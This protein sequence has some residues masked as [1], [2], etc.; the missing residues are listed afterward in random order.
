VTTTAI[1]TG[2]HPDDGE[3]LST[4][5]AAVMLGVTPRTLYRWIDEGRLAAYRFGKVVRLRRSDV[6]RFARDELP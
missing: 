2:D 6:E 4:A 5:R 3:W 1:A